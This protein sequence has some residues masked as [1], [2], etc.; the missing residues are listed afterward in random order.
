[1]NGH[2][3]ELVATS[4]HR[5]VVVFGLVGMAAFAVNYSIVRL[6]VP[7]GVPPLAANAL[8]F[9]CAFGV[10]YR[11]HG[12]WTFRAASPVRP[13][14]LRRFFAVALTGFA[15]NETLYWALLRFTSLSYEAALIIVL[16]AAAA[17]V[18]LL[19]KYW[20]FASDGN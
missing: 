11:G 17:L 20:A 5:E 15:V 13:G 14:A 8:G 1:M 9:I 18:L 2:F 7:L 16:A 4:L 10:S 19:S 3:R 6:T 12:R